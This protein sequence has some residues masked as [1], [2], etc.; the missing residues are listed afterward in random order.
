MITV[1]INLF[2]F[3]PLFIWMFALWINSA[4]EKHCVMLLLHGPE[5]NKDKGF[6][7]IHQHY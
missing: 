3:S 1:K 4:V 6:F 2:F 5:K 7:L